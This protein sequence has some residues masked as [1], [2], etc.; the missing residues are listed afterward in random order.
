MVEANPSENIAPPQDDDI[1]DA[2]FEA[3]V[4]NMPKMTQEEQERDLEDFINHPLNCRELTPEMLQNENFQ[5]LMAMQQEGTDL[6][7]QQNFKNHAYDHLGKLLLNKSKN[8]EKDFQEALYCFDSAL[9]IEPEVGDPDLEY[10][11]YLGRA[12]LNILRNQCGHTKD[13]CLQALKR[14]RKEEQCWVVLI[15]SRM[16]IEKWDE[17][18]KYIRDA[19]LELPG[20]Q[21]LVMLR[22]KCDEGLAAE[23][24]RVKKIDIIH[25]A[26][27]DR[28]MAV[29]RNIRGKGIKLGKRIHELPEVVDQFVKLTNRQKL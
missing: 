28:M 27:E 6:E 1:T 9:E 14:K 22:A 17:A 18:S 16:F 13:D 7:R 11:L 15:R 4:A 23:I 12:K 8:E 24:E 29:Y 19:S 25:E 21:K 2:E 3:M 5:A 26:R 10:D 20:N